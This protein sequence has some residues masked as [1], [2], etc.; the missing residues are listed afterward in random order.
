MATYHY[1]HKHTVTLTPAQKTSLITFLSAV[2]PGDA[3]DVTQVTFYRD[4]ENPSTLLAG[5][6]G[7]MSTADINDLEAGMLLTQIDP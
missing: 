6:V 3:N 2:W 4:P 1:K 5:M 7:S